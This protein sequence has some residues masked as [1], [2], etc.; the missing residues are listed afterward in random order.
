MKEFLRLW[1]SGE[2]K[3]LAA[4]KR[5]VKMGGREFQIPLLD[6][7]SVCAVLVW[8]PAN[9]NE[10]I[11]RILFP[12][13]APQ[14]KILDG[15]EKMRH[16][17]FLKVATCTPKSLTPVIMPVSAVPS[18][19]KDA[20][21]TKS[22]ASINSSEKSAE[23]KVKAADVA[24]VAK[25]AKT[26]SS[27]A[28]KLK[29]E[30]PVK[31]AAAAAEV[32]KADQS[33]NDAKDEPDKDTNKIQDSNKDSAKSDKIIEKK[34]KA[35]D[36]SDAK[37]DKVVELRKKIA[38]RTDSGDVHA[39]KKTESKIDAFKSKPKAQTVKKESSSNAAAPPLNKIKKDV[40]NLRMVEAKVPSHKSPAPKKTE[41]KKTGDKQEADK[42]EKKVEKKTESSEP[43]K[44]RLLWVWFPCLGLEPVLLYQ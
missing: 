2:A 39:H 33:K 10:A 11:T 35:T 27:A 12:G 44:K 8:E 24:E 43:V 7:I 28:A 9:P 1:K 25:T 19:L 26:V 40:A 42:V 34:I 30:K 14:S 31:V 22:Q 32:K 41:D 5:T 21:K 20:T 38:S 15:L 6:M 23:K 37:E 4:A 36:S 29:I 16:V 13:S 17:E 3:G 18:K